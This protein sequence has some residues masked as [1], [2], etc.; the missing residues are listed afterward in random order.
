M[1]AAAGRGPAP[2]RR[3]TMTSSPTLNLHDG[4]SIPQLGSGGGQ[5]ER[6]A[7][8]Q[9]VPTARL[10]GHRHIDPA[11]AYG[12]EEGVGRALKAAGLPR[13]E[14]FVTSKVPNEAQGYESTPRSVEASLPDLG[15]EELDLHLIHWPRPTE[16]LAVDTWKA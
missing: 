3:R 13:D 6:D 16:G 12:N 4:R 11:R 10:A 14:V 1:A 2:I 5:V 15:L 7:A 9:A 8:A